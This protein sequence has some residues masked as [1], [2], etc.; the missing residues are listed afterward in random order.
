MSRNA[1]DAFFICTYV[2]HSW[3]VHSHVG[4]K[5]LILR[6]WRATIAE[7]V[8]GKDTVKWQ[9]NG[10]NAGGSTS[11]QLFSYFQLALQIHLQ[12]IGLK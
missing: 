1:S 7:G 9:Q 6:D 3:K 12:F 8:G 2:P 4:G 10:R 5:I 11:E